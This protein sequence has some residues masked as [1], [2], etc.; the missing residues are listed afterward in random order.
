MPVLDM[1]D[2]KPSVQSFLTVGIMA[3][4]FIALAKVL[5]AR[6]KVPGLSDLINSV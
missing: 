3:L 2:V 4:L 5:M 6:W 1:A